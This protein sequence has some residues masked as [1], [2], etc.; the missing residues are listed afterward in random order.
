MT[1]PTAGSTRSPCS[2]SRAR[3]YASRSLG[4]CPAHMATLW[5]A[6]SSSPSLCALAPSARS[7]RR[8]MRKSRLP[9]GT[10]C[11]FWMGRRRPT[12]C[13]FALAAIPRSLAAGLMLPASTLPASELGAHKKWFNFKDTLR[14]LTI[15]IPSFSCSSFSQLITVLRMLL[16]VIVLNSFCPFVSSHSRPDHLS[17]LVAIYWRNDVP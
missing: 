8:L 11:S 14:T 2:L 12:A 3:P 15:Y 5:A 7:L 17:L 1:G 16:L 6:A 9:G 10:S 13:L 4:R